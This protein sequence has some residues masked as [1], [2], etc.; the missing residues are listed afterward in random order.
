MPTSLEFDTAHRYTDTRDGIPVPVSLVIGRQSVELLAKLDTG[1]AHCIFERK[2]GEM[3]EIDV[4]SGRLQRFR[5]VAGSFAAYEQEV[6]IQTLGIE[7]PAVVFFAQDSTF[8]RNFLGRSGWLDR[9]RVGMIDYE[10]ML[11]VGTYQS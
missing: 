2:Y 8:S 6:I 5:T 4:E 9:P 11:F 7:F 1:A 10:R 3:L